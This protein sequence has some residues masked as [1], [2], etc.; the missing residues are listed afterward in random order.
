MYP[1]QDRDPGLAVIYHKVLSPLLS[2][3]GLLIVL[4]REV[5]EDLITLTDFLILIRLVPILA[6]DR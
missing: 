3:L 6:N 1:L 4:N 2:V 5:P